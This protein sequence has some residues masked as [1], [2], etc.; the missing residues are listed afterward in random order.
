[1]DMDEAQDRAIIGAGVCADDAARRAR[2]ADQDNLTSLIELEPKG[3]P[4]GV[5]RSMIGFVPV[6]E[7]N[8]ALIAQMADPAIRIVDL[9]VTEGGY[10]M[11]PVTKGFDADHPDI[12]H[13]ATHAQIP[14][15]FGIENAAPVT[16][17]NF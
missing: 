1:M 17:E 4:A 9:T 13:D 11:D 2:L 15:S 6:E 14:R 16:L 10:Y 8:A 5:I 3:R 12:V 7:G